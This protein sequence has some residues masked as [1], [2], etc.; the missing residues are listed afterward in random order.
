MTPATQWRGDYEAHRLQLG[1]RLGAPLMP[2]VIETLKAAAYVRVSTTLQAETG[3]SLAEQKEVI[4]ARIKAE[5]WTLV[6]VYADE[7]ISG[8]RDDRPE[9]ERLLRDLPGIDRVVV[10]ELTRLGRRAKGMLDLFDRFEAQ[11]VGLVAIRQSID[12]STAAGKL[13]R[14]VLVAVAEFESEQLGERVAAVSASK[15]AKG[16][17]HGRPPYGYKRKG[18]EIVV[19][20]DEAKIVRRIYNEAAAKIGQRIIA[21]NLNAD[22]IKPQRAKRW[23][24]SSVGAIL[25][26]P[27]YYGVIRFNE[28]LLPG[29]HEAIIEREQF[30]AV[31]KLREKETRT[32]DGGPGRLPVGPHLFT[33]GLLRCASCGSALTPRTFRERG[34]IVRESYL[35]MNRIENGPEACPLPIVSR[36]AVDLAALDYFQRAALDVE[37]LERDL[38]AALS[39]KRAIVGDQVKRAQTEERTATDRLTRIR[40]DYQD[41]KLDA[42]DW[43]EQREEL[44]AELEGARAELERAEAREAE[45]VAAEEASGEPRARALERLAAIRAAVAGELTDAE[46]IDQLR[47]AL[48]EMFDVFWIAPIDEDREL[49]DDEKPLVAAARQTLRESLAAEGSEPFDADDLL[50]VPTPKP[51]LVDGLDTALQPVLKRRGLAGKTNEHEEFCT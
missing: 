42:D 8:K 19:A 17:H 14:T 48:H 23:T 40:R 22:G 38:T 35:C 31:A 16:Q 32:R 28:Q 26:N 9:L 39:E 30:E 41:G 33:R 37:Q 2:L 25:R 20:P 36:A 29:A 49:T 6:D 51:E 15:A 10:T 46:G 43:R 4:A 50:I 45:L 7:G 47:A 44:T 18:S 21:R 34:E 27:T 24:Q 1:H 12:T 13:L 5:G 11:G 3:L